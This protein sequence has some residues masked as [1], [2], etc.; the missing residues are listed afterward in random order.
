MGEWIHRLPNLNG[1]STCAL[2][3]DNESLGWQGFQPTASKTFTSTAFQR[4]DR[5]SHEENSQGIFPLILARSG[6]ERYQS[7]LEKV[8]KILSDSKSG[9]ICRA[10]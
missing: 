10:N 2:I 1:N 4:I 8:K 6:L 9:Y 5:N 7:C 3:V